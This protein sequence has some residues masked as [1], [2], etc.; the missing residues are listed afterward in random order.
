MNYRY[1]YYPNFTTE[2]MRLKLGYVTA[3]LP[4]DHRALAL[5]HVFGGRKAPWAV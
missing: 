1:V 3:D 2:E 5:N 4:D